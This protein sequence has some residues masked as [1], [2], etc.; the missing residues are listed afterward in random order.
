M[1]K[2]KSGFTIVE[3]TIVVVILAILSTISVVM[4]SR[5]Q[6]D[7]RNSERSTKVSVIADALEHYYTKNGEYPSCSAMTQ[8]GAVVSQS[9]LG[10]IS[11][12]NLIAPKSEAGTTSS[13]T[14]LPLTAGNGPDTF[15]YVGDGSTTCNTGAACLTFKIQYR[16]EGTGAIKEVLAQHTV[17]ISSTSAPTLTATAGGETSVG[18]SWT[19]VA[20]A[21]SYRYQRA[22]D[23]AFTQNMVQTTTASLTAN[24]TGLTP[25][26]TYYFRVLAVTGVGDGAWSNTADATTSIQAP[27][28]APVVS[29]AMSG[30]NAVG[31]TGTVTCSSGT[32]QYQI[33]YRSTATATMGSWSSWSAWGTGLTRTEAAL[34]GYQYGFQAQARCFGQTSGS[35]T[36]ALSN[37][38][39]TV[40]PI[41]TPTAPTWVTPSSMQSNV[42][43]IVNWSGSCPSGT[44]RVNA[45]FR[46]KDWLGGTWGPHPW[47]YNDSWENASSSNKNVEYW[48]KFR[49]QTTYSTSSYTSETYKV[50]VVSP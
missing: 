34:Q 37:I 45:T 7:T 24:A 49:C 28:A 4:Y 11:Q 30:T 33:R 10:G 5:V 27:P 2:N 42:F 47:G 8:D 20:S 13:I 40:R 44:N 21:V 18:L 32:P 9:I 36:T 26:S 12:S 29:A 50:I 46:S 1:I 3:V 31:T 14:C 16:E 23:A 41:A 15:A 6:A 17:K 38:A 39:T 48:G 25:G 43:A 22:T 19:A 35:N